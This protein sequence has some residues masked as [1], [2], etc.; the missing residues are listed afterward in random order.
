MNEQE[1][2]RKE[3]RSPIHLSRLAALRLNDSGLW[4]Q[5]GYG[6]MATN[7]AFVGFRA[8]SVG[9]A[10]RGISSFR[11]HL[12]ERNAQILLSGDFPEFRRLLLWWKLL[13]RH[14]GRLLFPRPVRRGTATPTLV[15]CQESGSNEKGRQRVEDRIPP[16]VLPE[17]PGFG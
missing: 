13:F 3:R 11:L 9:H 1:A 15:L 4:L 10:G 5:F 6:E 12:S 2:E 14:T 7:P 16:E 8:D 17:N